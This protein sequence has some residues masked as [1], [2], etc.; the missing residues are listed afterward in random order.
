MA[1]ADEARKLLQEI[2]HI[3]SAIAAMHESYRRLGYRALVVEALN[4]DMASKYGLPTGV[5]IAHGGHRRTGTSAG[6]QYQR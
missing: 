1:G 6:R 5:R 2:A 3:Q 4:D